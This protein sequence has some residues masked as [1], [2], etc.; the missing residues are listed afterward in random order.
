M[1]YEFDVSY[2][3]CQTCTSKIHCEKCEKEIEESML[4][5]DGVNEATIK[6]IEKRMV[7]DAE[8]DEDDLIDALEAL[9]VFA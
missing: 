6:I 1:K 2:M 5:L 4:K 9:G 7:I 8:V 3:A